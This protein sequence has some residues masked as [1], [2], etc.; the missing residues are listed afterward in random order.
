MA[1]RSLPYL[2]TESAG[3]LGGAAEMFSSYQTI[4][5]HLRQLCGSLSLS[6]FS[7]YWE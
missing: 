5:A 4:T 6:Q 3:S 7:H 2:S 1:G